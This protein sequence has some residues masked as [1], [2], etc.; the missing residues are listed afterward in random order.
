[1][2]KI[3]NEKNIKFDKSSND[4]KSWK[5]SKVGFM[6]AAFVLAFT[7]VPFLSTGSANAVGDAP[8]APTNAQIESVQDGIVKV[9]WTNGSGYTADTRIQIALFNGFGGTVTEA[10]VASDKTSYL[11]VGVGT[12][13]VKA[14]LYAQNGTET[15]AGATSPVLN[16]TLRA[17]ASASNFSDISKVSAEAKNAIIWAAG[18]GVTTGYADGT[19]K[20]NGYTTRG[21]MASFFHRF[22]GS[23]DLYGTPI[24]FRDISGY[25]AKS[26]IDWL[27]TQN[28]TQGYS[29][30]A[31]GKPEAACTKKGD[32]VYRPNVAVTRLQMAQFL[33]KFA[34]SP[35]LSDA[36]VDQYLA[37]LKDKSL[38]VSMDQ[39]IAVAWLIKNGISGGYEDGTFKPANRVTRQQMA[40]FLQR[41][42]YAADVV[43]TLPLQP[44][45]DNYFGNT[46]VLSRSNTT[47]LN[48]ENTIPTCET[49]TSYDLTADQNGSIKACVSGTTVTI[50]QPGGVVANE[51]SQYLFARLNNGTNGPRINGFANMVV[52]NVTNIS[53]AF[54]Q[55]K[56]LNFAEGS[57]LIHFGSKVTD[58]TGVFTQATLGDGLILPDG[59]GKNATTMAN[60]FDNATITGDLFWQNTTLPDTVNV[61][62]MWTSTTWPSDTNK[63]VYVSTD[64]M[65]NIITGTG[66]AIGGNADRVVVR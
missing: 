64:V 1:M 27:S 33:Y 5:L 15:S 34:K 2:L 12:G 49:G 61:T 30:T 13:S 38:L 62:N 31:K 20:P 65:K 45:T 25:G 58:Y 60:M 63:N 24:D 39:R 36:E 41:D 9:S 48:I 17:T 10:T 52:N 44:D 51:N 47:E 26:D 35:N 28:I 55:S 16:V 29:C 54:K 19:F 50:G 32:L 40:L 37:N 46:S 22:G 14:V 6:L 23:F 59:F 8:A 53:Y 18:Y 21:Q 56:L 66:S 57:N 43:S 42:A 3:K 11:F 4:T 7:L